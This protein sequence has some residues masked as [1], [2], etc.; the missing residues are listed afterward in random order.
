MQ[1]A[2]RD[3]MRAINRDNVL[4]TIRLQ[5]N[6][7]RKEIAE[8]TG[9]GQSTVTDITASLIG[10]GLI[11]EKTAPG[12]HTGRPPILLALN[13]DGAFVAGA[14]ISS[15]KISVVVI[16]L[17]ARVIGSHALPLDKSIT[18]PEAIADRIAEAVRTC[19]TRYGFI[20]EDISGLGLGIPGLVNSD[21]G[22]IHFHPG[23]NKG[24]D[25]TDIPFKDL[26][27]KRTGFQTF[28]ENSSNT[29]AIYEHWFGASR[30]IDNFF[31]VTLEHGIGLGLY[32]NGALVRGW[33]GIAGEFGHVRGDARECTCRCGMKGCLEAMA[34]PHAILKEAKKAIISGRW[35]PLHP[36]RITLEEVIRAAESGEKALQD[37]FTQAGTI[38]GQ[39]IADL[40]RILD[41][42]TI[43]ITGKSNLAKD[44]LFEP[45]A[46]AMETCTSEVFRVT[47]KL[48]ISPWQEENYA[49][50]AG[51]L[52]LQKL[53]QS[54]A[55]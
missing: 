29:L 9:L 34:S 21:E 26:V 39:R 35:H 6:I 49:R 52:V 17:E 45:L 8:Q 36:D 18:T 4:R 24:F 11:F 23:F 51:A 7:S 38:L 41:P 37:I 53:H 3:L 5:G 48:V 40:T 33:Q 44:M 32:V 28:I 31:V 19:C 43:I 42:E 46:Q 54:C 55:L 14:Y 47:P 30:G 10:E 2:N 15:G 22:L 12:K 27:E 13:P 50:G 20:P 16:N 25:W 1:A